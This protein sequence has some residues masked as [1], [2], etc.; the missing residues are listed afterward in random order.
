LAVLRLKSEGK[1]PTD[2]YVAL[3]EAETPQQ[4]S[5][6]WRSAAAM[7]R[8]ASGKTIR[9]CCAAFEA[10]LGVLPPQDPLQILYDAEEETMRF[11]LEGT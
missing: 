2:L 9:D 7:R 3:T 10:I 5:D 1:S 8:V 6:F 11:T 4:P